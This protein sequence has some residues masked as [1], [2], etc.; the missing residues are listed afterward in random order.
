M[1]SDYTIIIDPESTNGNGFWDVI[2]IGDDDDEEVQP[3]GAEQEEGEEQSNAIEISDTE[4]CNE[5]EEVGPRPRRR[6][7]LP[8]WARGDFVIEHPLPNR[9]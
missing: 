5:A 2:V 8:A 1:A 4:S 9:R 3:Q 6:G 7:R